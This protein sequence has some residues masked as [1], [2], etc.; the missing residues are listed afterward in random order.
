MLNISLA[1][2]AVKQGEVKV[3]LEK[4]ASCVAEAARR[5]SRLI[6]FPEMWTTGFGFEQNI[7]VCTKQDATIEAVAKL[8]KE[9]KIWISGSMLNHN[10]EGR[11]TNSHMLFSDQGE[12]VARYDK[13]HL[14]SFMSEDRF[15]APGD[16]LQSV[17]APWGKMGLSVCYDIR[18]CEIFRSYALMGANMVLSPMAFPYPRLEHWQVLVRARAIENQM[19]MIGTNQVGGENFDSV[20][21]GEVT[22]FGHSCIIDPWGKTIIE[23]G[24]SEEVLLTVDINVDLSNQIRNKMHV[25]Q[26]RRTDLYQLN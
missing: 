17:D 6:C 18:F 11:P 22:Y 8:A 2:M 1:Q 4:A 7:Q 26:D 10:G 19:F 3:N 16:H 13:V 25:L 23:A 12:L 24:D 14:F 21:F 5:G 20:G 9:H 15:V